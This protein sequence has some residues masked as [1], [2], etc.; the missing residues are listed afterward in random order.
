MIQQAAALYQQKNYKSAEMLCKKLLKKEPKNSSAYHLMGVIHYEKKGFDKAITYFHRTIELAPNNIDALVALASSYE[1]LK[2][3]EQAIHYFEIAYKSNPEQR[4]LL[5]EACR[6]LEQSGYAEKA[7]STLESFLNQSPG[8]IDGLF[9]LVHLLMRLRDYSRAKDSVLILQH[10]IPHNP[11]VWNLTGLIESNL[12]AV[13][14]AKHSFSQALNLDPNHFHAKLNFASFL[15]DQGLLPDAKRHYLEI[16]ENFNDACRENYLQRVYYNLALIELGYGDFKNGWAHLRHRPQCSSSLPCRSELKN[17]NILIKGEEGLGDEL[18]FL[19]FI[20]QLKEQ[21]NHISYLTSPKLADLL[22]TIPSID[23][24]L[25]GECDTN[26]YNIEFS[27]MD[28]P[29]IFEIDNTDALPPPIKIGYS[30]KKEGNWS[31]QK[32]ANEAIVGL[33]WKAGLLDKSSSAEK[34]LNKE[35]PLYVIKEILSHFHGTIVILQ[36]DLKISE[37]QELIDSLSHI[38]FINAS[39]LND[40]LPVMLNTLTF[41]DAYIGVSNTN[42]HLYG[43]LGKRGCVITPYPGEWRW[44]YDESSS[45]WYPD[46]DII[47]QNKND[48][49]ESVIEESKHYLNNLKNV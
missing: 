8:N 35:I 26:D 13:T 9:K 17:K 31:D 30:E 29:I 24:V 32:K 3:Y 25:I 27:L 43:S 2:Q 1:Q 48:N 39:D 45:P 41:L 44:M 11:D 14:E 37:F 40:N 34:F 47:R 23:K 38:K 46:F 36:R 20:P 22:S 10:I 6:L 5:F 18:M 7:A 33:S 28:L 49:W 21:N 19:R 15:Q 42:M 4:N 12:G 16:I